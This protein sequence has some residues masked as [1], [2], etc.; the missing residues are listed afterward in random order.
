MKILMTVKK[1]ET[2]DDQAWKEEIDTDE[3]MCLLHMDEGLEAKEYAEEVVKYFNN[4]LR[5]GQIPRE[6]VHAE[7]I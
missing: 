3:S 7:A 6:L 1:V 2:S 5:P 4:T